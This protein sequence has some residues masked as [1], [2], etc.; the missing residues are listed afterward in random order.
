[1]NNLAQPPGHLLLVVRAPGASDQHPGLIR[2]ACGAERT[3]GDLFVHEIPHWHRT[4]R[5][6][7]EPCLETLGV[8]CFPR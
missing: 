3:T 6:I 1:M 4:G 7:C 5:L 2:V 8:I